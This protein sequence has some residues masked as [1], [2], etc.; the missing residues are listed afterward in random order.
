M[1]RNTY[2]NE[3]IMFTNKV[4]HI[5]IWGWKGKGRVILIKNLIYIKVDKALDGYTIK[6]LKGIGING[7]K[8]VN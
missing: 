1:F 8:S 4:K 7:Q 5:I 2:L 3:N 6:D